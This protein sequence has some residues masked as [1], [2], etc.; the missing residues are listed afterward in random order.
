MESKE[1]LKRLL[2]ELSEQVASLP[3]EEFKKLQEGTHEISLKIQKKK[4]FG[5]V[6]NYL[7]DDQIKDLVKRLQDCRSRDDGVLLLVDSLKNKRELEQFARHLDVLVLKQD[8]VDVIR[9]KIIEA[10]VGAVLRSEA[11]QGKKT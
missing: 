3:H 11:I 6:A 2:E 4:S 8:K 9:E 5:T 7:S 1:V 10:T